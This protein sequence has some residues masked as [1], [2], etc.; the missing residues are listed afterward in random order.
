MDLLVIRLSDQLS[1]ERV[2]TRAPTPS[3]IVELFEEARSL[4]FVGAD[5]GQAQASGQAQATNQDR[6]YGHR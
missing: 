3:P 4:N 2:S 5:H 6:G 1:L